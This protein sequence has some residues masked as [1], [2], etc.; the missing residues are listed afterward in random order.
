MNETQ[1]RQS[2]AAP[3]PSLSPDFNQKLAERLNRNLQVQRRVMA[4][5]GC[6]AVLTCIVAMHAQG[7]DWTPISFSIGAALVIAVGAAKTNV[8][9]ASRR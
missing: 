2:L 3:V 9:S 4:G 5:Y 6:T 1:L 8:A 7:L